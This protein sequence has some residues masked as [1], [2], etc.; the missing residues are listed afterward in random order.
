MRAK[1]SSALAGLLC[2]L[3]GACSST[4]S[5][6]TAMNRS[7][8]NYSSTAGSDQSMTGS[9]AS[10]TTGTGSTSGSGSISSAGS[11]DMGST[12]TSGSDGRTATA[13]NASSMDGSQSGVT[14]ASATVM[15]IEPVARGMD[16]GSGETQAGS[17]GT[18]GSTA[19]AAAGG[20]GNMMYRVTL[21]LDD[22]STRAIMQNSQPGY[23]VGDRVKMV[24]GLLQKN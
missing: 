17:S 23:Q 3:L 19:G 14:I 10:G 21:R 16:L 11:S 2:L 22:G 12:G 8:E 18:A 4:G 6:S 7:G 13:N 24:N 5:D 15:S 1:T 9:G 20:T